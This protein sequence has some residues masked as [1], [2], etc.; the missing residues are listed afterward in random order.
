MKHSKELS[1]SRT[2]D[3]AQ[4]GIDIAPD[5]PGNLGRPMI[6]AFPGQHL[7]II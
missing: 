6:R 7:L 3:N 5:Q 1:N 2:K 4:P